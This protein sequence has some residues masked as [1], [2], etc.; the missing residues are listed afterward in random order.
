[1]AASTQRITRLA[2]LAEIEA[3]IDAIARPM[4][5][6]T[7]SIDVPFRRAL[8][9]DVT[10][11]KPHP[12]SAIALRAGWAVNAQTVADAGPYAPMPVDAIWTEAGAALPANADC[13]LPPDAMTEV[14]G[15]YEAMA[16]GTAGDGVLPSG[17]DVASGQVLRRAGT[18]LHPFQAEALGAA[19]VTE[20]AVHL[21]HVLVLKG[22]ASVVD[23]TLVRAIARIV[24]LEGAEPLT[25]SE[26]LGAG[27]ADDAADLTV[28]IGGSGEGRGDRSVSA[29]AKAG[30]VLIHGLGISPGADAAL[31]TVGTRPVLV[32]PGR[33]DAALAAWLI[34]GRRLLARL[35]GI[36][37]EERG[38]SASLTRKI[39]STVGLA[40]MVPV[41][42]SEGGVEPLASGYLPLHTLARA[43]GFVLV[44][45]ASEGY[46]AG[47]LVEVRR[48]P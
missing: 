37:E 8:A 29:L 6:Q 4:P 7:V 42:R 24:A 13:I 9:A 46:A 27:L 19:G 2:S 3:C 14:Q 25:A 36:T 15:R 28:V 20:I 34:V 30:R 12:E 33:F 22:E 18:W 11:A 1:M 26:G 31:G 23:D 39:V 47:S 16:S 45:P 48:F 21:P 43:E 40:E 44:P 35:A 5:T 10:V 41:G 17:A 38:G 32:L